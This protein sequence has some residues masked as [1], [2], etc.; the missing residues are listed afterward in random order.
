MTEVARVE[1]GLEMPGP[2]TLHWRYA[3]EVRGYLL[4]VKAGLLQDRKSV[5]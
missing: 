4:L 5:V 2:G 1:P 3:G